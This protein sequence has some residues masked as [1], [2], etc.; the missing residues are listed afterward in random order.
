M[1]VR[2]S[3]A[4]Q[5]GGVF[6]FYRCGNGGSD[7]ALRAWNGTGYFHNSNTGGAHAY[8]KGSGHNILWNIAPGDSGSYNFAPVYYV[9]AC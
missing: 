5:G 2:S 8:L 4:S 1:P 9:Q 3:L 7:W 6:S